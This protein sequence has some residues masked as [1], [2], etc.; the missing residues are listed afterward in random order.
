MNSLDLALFRFA[1]GGWSVGRLDCMWR[2]DYHFLLNNLIKKDFKT[3]YRNMSLGVFWSLLNPLVTMSVLYF[4]FVKVF[5]NPQPHFGIF[6]LCGLVPFNFFTL[7][8]S[9]GTGSLVDNA[10]IMKRVPVPRLVIPVATVLGNCLHL[11]I[12]IALLLALTVASGLRVN[13]YWLW[14]PFVWGMEILFVCGLALI[15]SAVNVYVRDTR[16]VVEAANSVLFWM[17]PVF[18]PFSIIPARFAE[19]Y[20]L[21]PIAA[22]VLA[23]R[24]ILL[25]GVPPPTSLLVRLCFIS[26]FM[27][28][29][30]LLVFRHL[31]EGFYDYL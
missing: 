9:T 7:A 3:R 2:G 21:N 6:I 24:N 8:W 15:S 30:G 22:L 10:S 1:F 29:V 13:Q 5:K 26:L 16:Y 28:G 17:V 18:Y 14:L 11:L 25:E 31:K 27:L 4:V 12:Q 20:K 23:L 19:I